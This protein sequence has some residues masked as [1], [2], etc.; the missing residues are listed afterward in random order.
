MNREAIM[1]I[2]PHRDPF[3]LVDEIIELDLEKQEL[4]G[5]KYI[6]PKMAIFQGHFPERPIF[7]GVLIVEALAQTA[8]VLAL[9]SPK[10]QGTIP[11]FA[12]INK[13]SFK[14]AVLPNDILILKARLIKERLGMFLAEVEA[15]VEEVVVAKGE[16]MCACR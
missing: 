7:P 5:K 4:K 6:D 3:L 16:I 15:L 2:I 11:Y 9:K 13:M 8:A 10:Y 1:Q 14:K 12:G